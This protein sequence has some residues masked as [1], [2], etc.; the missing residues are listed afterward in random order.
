[1]SRKRHIATCQFEPTVGDAEA[2]YNRI[3]ELT[4][5]LNDEVTLAVFPEL[6]VTGYDLDVAEEWA[7]PVPGSITDSLVEIAAKHNVSLVVGVPEQDGSALYNT[8][9]LVDR[10]G[11][12]AVYRKQYPWGDESDV[13]DRGSGPVTVETELGTIGFLICYGL[14]FP[15]AALS[16][17]RAECDI[18]V[19]SAAW[20]KSYIDDWNVLLQSRALDGTCY[21]VG[22]NHVGTQRSRRHGACSLIADPCGVVIESAGKSESSIAAAVESDRLREGRERNPVTTYR[23][24][25]Q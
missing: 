1:M 10:T 4:A 16:Y 5:S 19:V 25:T 12:Q 7:T 17:A 20:R 15:E 14:N 11:V 24:Q 2:N 9:V 22:S 21:V 13:F 23:K 3:A 18:L 8:L 6:C